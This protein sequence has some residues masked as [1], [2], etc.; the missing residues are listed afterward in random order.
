MNDFRRLYPGK[1]NKLFSSIT[2]KK[3]EIIKYASLKL[4][5]IRDQDTRT[6][7]ANIVALIDGKKFCSNISSYY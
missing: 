3:E 7:I 1:E 2:L 6:K 4:R 5:K